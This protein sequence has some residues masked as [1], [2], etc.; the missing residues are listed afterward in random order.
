M[1]PIMLFSVVIFSFLLISCASSIYNLPDAEKDP[2]ISR[3]FDA[4]Y[5]TAFNSC[6]DA[7]GEDGWIV[8]NSDKESGN[9]VTDYKLNDNILTSALMGQYRSK[10]SLR[11]KKID[12]KKSKVTLTIQSEREKAAGSWEPETLT[13]YKYESQSKDFWA[14]LSSKLQ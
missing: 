5:A 4:T 11:V 10:F 2:I 1:K 8:T 12:D 3:T 13:Q 6:M 9:I 14:K 7:L